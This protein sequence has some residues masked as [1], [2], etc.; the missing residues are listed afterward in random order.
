M[1]PSKLCTEYKTSYFGIPLNRL[2]IYKILK[3]GFD[4]VRTRDWSSALTI[5]IFGNKGCQKE[6]DLWC[7]GQ[8]ESANPEEINYGR[9]LN[10][11]TKSLNGKKLKK[12]IKRKSA[13]Q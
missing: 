5:G 8:D 11:K 10:L 7:S 4:K 12:E 9:R 3:K 6:I 2:Q 1:R 13:E